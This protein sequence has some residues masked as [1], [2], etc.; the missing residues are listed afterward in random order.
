MPSRLSSLLSTLVVL[1]LTLVSGKLAAVEAV[2]PAPD[3]SRLE[4]IARQ[5]D[6]LAETAGPGGDLAAA[7]DALDFEA[8]LI[9]D[10][11]RDVVHFEPYA[12]ALKGAAGTLSAGAGN[13]LDQALLLATLLRDAGYDARIAR[14]SLADAELLRLARAALQPPSEE[15]IAQDSPGLARELESLKQLVDEPP[16]LQ[17]PAGADRVGEP[18]EQVSRTAKR[19]AGLVSFE[20]ASA[21]FEQAMRDY[22]WVEWREGPGDGWVGAHPAFGAEAPPEVVAN[23]FFGSSI[24]EELQHRIRVEM[25]IERLESG[26]LVRASLAE[27]WERPVA[28]FFGQSITIG[29]VP[30]QDAVGGAP[31]GI[32]LPVFNGRTAPGG[33]VFNNLGQI[34]DLDAASSPAAGVFDKVSRSFLD[35]AESISNG[36][37]NQPLLAL[38]GHFVRVSW[39]RP[40]G[41]IR[42]EERWLLDRIANRAAS[43]EAPRIAPGADE[44][45]MAAQLSYIRTYL[46]QPPGEHSASSL[47]RA[48]D[49]AASRVRWTEGMLEL[50]D[51]AEARLELDPARAPSI[52]DDHP[53]LL[54]LASLAHHP[55]R[56][57]QGRVTW[58]D[59]PFVAALH[60]SLEPDAD[61][62]SWLDIHFNPWRGAEIGDAGLRHWP[63]GSVM[64]GVLDTAWEAAVAAPQQDYLAPAAERIELS[65][66]PAGAAQARDKAEGFVLASIPS[67]GGER[68]WRL[69]PVTGEVLGMSAF[70]G[71]ITTEYVVGVISVGV[72][73]LLLGRS[74]GTCSTID[75]TTKRRCCY[76]MAAAFGVSGAAGVGAGILASPLGISA[77][78]ALFSGA[79]QIK[80]M[81]V[82]DQVQSLATDAMCN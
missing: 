61:P 10:F 51:W 55:L 19:L 1:S 16:P 72:G 79:M 52:A 31:S 20:D 25:G 24:P 42:T 2:P 22:F 8:G 40:D 23:E 45:T 54:T 33:K 73:A 14:G 37:E 70:G 76:A 50:L 32:F 67:A 74:A 9:V 4:A 17:E 3:R 18:S 30:M 46:V 7:N 13:A 6:A 47:R 80:A 82:L 59:G 44:S 62:R 53:M 11:V 12:G 63:E 35:A 29:V 68:W 64:R 21:E 34:I 60:Q 58:R 15:G 39:I 49:S 28:N 71:A 81:V 48:F 27:P 75:N 77:G 78:A 36:A 65:P 26:R 43:G 41:R 38:A 66:S 5:F 69:H 56:V 57:S